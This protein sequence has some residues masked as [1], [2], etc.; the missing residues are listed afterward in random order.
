[1]Y[2]QKYRATIQ[3]QNKSAYNVG[4]GGQLYGISD[5]TIIIIDTVQTYRHPID[6]QSFRK[7]KPSM[8]LSMEPPICF[9]LYKKR[10][11]VTPTPQ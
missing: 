4:E 2:E 3:T 1:M 9:S 10:V 8:L 5:D 11:R 7:Q 6:G